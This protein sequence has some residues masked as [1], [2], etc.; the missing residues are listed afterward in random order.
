MSSGK[1]IELRGIPVSP[2]IIIGKARLIDRSKVKVPLRKIDKNSVPH[3]IERFKKAVEEAKKQLSKLKEKLPEKLKEHA[4]IL[5]SHMM[6][7]N[8]NMLYDAT[9]KRIKEKEINA[10]W[11][12]MES[13][14][15]IKNLF[16]QIEDKYISER[17]K[18]VENVVQR[19][20]R[21]LVGDNK[22]DLEINEKSII[23]AQELSPADTAGLDTKKVMGFITDGGGTTS[24]TA[25]LARALELPA[26]M[27]LC[28]ATKK[29]EDGNILIVDGDSGK[30]I[31][32]PDDE[33]II[34]YQEKKR[35]RE[36][37]RSFI[38]KE[39]NKPAITT[40]G[41]RVR[42][43]AN[44]ELVE[45]VYILKEVGAEGIG[46]YRT[47]FQYLSRS[48]LPTEEE[49]FQDYRKVAEIMSPHPV[50]I[51]TLDIGGDK[52]K[53]EFIKT[54]ET[55]PALGLRAIRFCLK[56]PHIFKT[57]LKAILMASAYGNVQ[58]MLPMI[59][60]LDEVLKTK[61]LLEEIKEELERENISYDPKIKVG[62]ILEVPSSVMIV[63]ILA[64]HVDF[65]SIG[66]NDLIQY[67]LAIDRT[68]K[69]VA[70]LYEPF[71]PSIIRMIKNLIEIADENN[72]PLS[73]CG[74]M[75]GDPLCVPVLIGLGL[76]QL[77]MNSRMIPFI[78]KL[79]RSLSVEELKKDIE[80]IM[81]MDTSKQIRDYILNR[82][83]ELFPEIDA[84]GEY[85]YIQADRYGE[86]RKEQ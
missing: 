52:F 23:V 18:D 41:H 9:I 24:H 7:L 3:E 2:G 71:H 27:G 70:Y 29:I 16:S 74:E 42:V 72:I 33:D 4:F 61:S 26:V 8:D 49:L 84:I 13:F 17:V 12:L 79:I 77:S 60:S 58:I 51:R 37:L 68:N 66:T 30:V 69:E 73:I 28:S 81:K 55:N 14:E 46:L 78:K 50:I 38:L 25:I 83:K 59:S 75:A 56:N 15:E 19:I 36:K 64:K 32:N 85:F 39:A 63:D 22:D 48:N 65:F 57:Q 62:I 43:M 47:E 40:D 54:N 5:D 21:N 6:I 45:E 10:E 1:R 31:V 35:Q 11:A 67:T 82:M 53:D 86:K 34:Y 80:K 76:R 20:M 44:A